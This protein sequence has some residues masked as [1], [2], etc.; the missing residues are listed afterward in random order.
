[1]GWARG[2]LDSREIGYSVEATCEHP[3]G[4]TKGIDRGLA[5]ACGGVHGTAEGG[6]T[7]YVC[8]DHQ[9]PS[10]DGAGHVC[11]GCAGLDESAAGVADEASR[12]L[13]LRL[14]DMIADKVYP[15]GQ[16]P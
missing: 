5:Y 6:C 8:I 12:A 15:F 3:F 9:Y 2:I 14:D 7:R 1:M 11:A 10:P 16:Q 13:F 4:C